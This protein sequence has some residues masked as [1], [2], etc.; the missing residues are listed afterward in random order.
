MT[1]FSF[2]HFID[3]IALSSAF[4]CFW[5][6]VTGNSYHHSRFEMGLFSPLWASF[7]LFFLHWFVH[8]RRMYLDIVFLLL[9][10]FLFLKILLRINWDFWT[11]GFV[12]FFSQP[13]VFPKKIFCPHSSPPCANLFAGTLACLIFSWESLACPNSHDSQPWATRESVFSSSFWHLFLKLCGV[14]SSCTQPGIPLMTNGNVWEFLELL[15]C[16]VP[17][18]PVPCPANTSP[19]SSPEV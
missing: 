5:W 6:E 12:F 11:G 9:C 13:L 15:L 16:T 10:F 18:S 7:R 4:H 2:Q 17:S 19:L 8:W 14:L 1:A 3:I